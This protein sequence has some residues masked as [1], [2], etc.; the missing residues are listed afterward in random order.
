MLVLRLDLLRYLR[1]AIDSRPVYV[2]GGTFGEPQ[3][4][5]QMAKYKSSA[6]FLTIQYYIICYLRLTVTR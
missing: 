6:N 5:C 4:T 2:N 3:T 1:S